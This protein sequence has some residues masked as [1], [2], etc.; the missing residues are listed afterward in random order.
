MLFP[1]PTITV[2][3]SMPKTILIVDDN[4]LLRTTL[5]VLLTGNFQDVG[6][7]EAANGAEAIEKARANPPD[8]VILDL[9]MPVMNG[10]IAAP[11]LKKL[12]PKA[13]ILLFT[14]Y[15]DEVRDPYQFGV[16]VLVPKAKGA[17]TFLNAVRELLASTAT[18][19][20]P[21]AE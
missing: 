13:P 21:T 3:D 4:D 2:P 17:D 6:F 11:S 7:V 20:R 15:A 19:I 10:L 8:L 9:A 5:A 14:L 18:P 1:Q 16:D 12:A